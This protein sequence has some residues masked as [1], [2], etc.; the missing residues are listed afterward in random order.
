MKLNQ[1]K[2]MSHEYCATVVRLNE[3]RPIEN[4]DFLGVTT[5]EGRDIVVRKDSV[6][7]G[8]VMIYFSN[9]SQI[10]NQFLF[11]N[12]EYED[13][14]LNSNYEEVSRMIETMQEEASTEE[15]QDYVRRHRGYF[16][17]YGRV[18]M[19]RLRGVESMGYLVKPENLVKAYPELSD[20]D[21]ENEV[22]TDFDTVG[23]QLLV[24]AYV[25]YKKEKQNSSGNRTNKRLKKFD[26]MI[27][28][29]FSFHYDTQQFERSIQRFNPDTR[30]DISVKL[31]GSSFIIG[32]VKVK[33]PR[34]KGFYTKIFNYLPSWLQFTDEDYDVVYSSRKVI[35]NSTINPG[36]GPGYS[37]GLT[38]CFDAWYERLK[39]YVPK[40]ITL[41]GEI[42]GY[43]EGSTRGIQSLG[44][45]VY[46]YGCKPG[47]NQF[48]IYRVVHTE[49][50]EYNISQVQEFTQILKNMVRESSPEIADRIRMIDLLYE[51]TL[52][53]LYPELDPNQHWHEE[54]L[55]RLK[56]DKSFYMEMNEPLCKNKLPREGVVIRII[57]DP[58]KEAFKLKCLKF[59]GKEA[60]DVDKGLGDAEMQERY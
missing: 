6:K 29:Q 12:N 56:D 11:F 51:G 60:E 17:K 25:P 57:D 47:E 14:T 58:V 37:T 3:V 36:K 49:I 59:L 35:Q 32:N 13:I 4:S 19:K 28:G 26:R 10:S 45:K 52:G 39:D 1:S 43:E 42:V 48:M 33:V 31:H 40:N 27:P 38:A 34:W 23:D 55:K 5:V 8:D 46:D 7:E 30:V 18:R 24:Q 54:F 9:E 21:W 41:Y 44:G 50:G 53:D 15:I 22:G 20:V 16:N 2:D